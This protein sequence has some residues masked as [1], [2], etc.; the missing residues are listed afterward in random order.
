VLTGS[1]TH[2]GQNDQANYEA[3]YTVGPILK[4]VKPRIATLEQTFGLMTHEQHQ[5]NFRMLLYDIGKAGYDLRYKLQDMSK[6]GLV[7]KRKRLLIIAA[8]YVQSSRGS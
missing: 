3:I 8:R 5:C 6:L 2:D 7:Q 1:S 4:A